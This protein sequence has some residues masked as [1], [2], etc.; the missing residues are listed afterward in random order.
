MSLSGDIPVPQCRWH[1]RRALVADE[2][3]CRS[4]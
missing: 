2:R 3:V 1:G 4:L